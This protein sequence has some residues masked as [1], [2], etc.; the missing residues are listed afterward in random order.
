[1]LYLL[2][3]ASTAE[4]L[5]LQWDYSVPSQLIKKPWWSYLTRESQR[6]RL[7]QKVSTLVNQIDLLSK[8]SLSLSTISHQSL[9]RSVLCWADSSTHVSLH[10]SFPLFSSPWSFRPL[11]RIE[12]S[13]FMKRNSQFSKEKELFD[14]V[15]VDKETSKATERFVCHFNREIYLSQNKRNEENKVKKLNVVKK[16]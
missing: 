3:S 12:R 7:G 1:M 14:L 15:S 5:N 8:F 10:K 2:S 13:S 6:I 4:P 16:K 9:V 11:G